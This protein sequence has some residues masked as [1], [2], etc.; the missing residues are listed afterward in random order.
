MPTIDLSDLLADPSWVSA[1]TSQDLPTYLSKQRWYTSKGA[2]IRGAK[3]EALPWDRADEGLWLLSLEFEAAQP[4]TRLLT[5]RVAGDRVADD[6]AHLLSRVPGGAIVEA[7][8]DASFR[9]RLYRFIRSGATSENA[10]GTLR[11]D[12]GTALAEQ[13][14]SDSQLPPQNS[15]N[16]V[17]VYEPDGFLKLFRKTEPGLHPDAE[18]IRYLSEECGFGSVPVY[19]GALSFEPATGGEPLSL[20]LL[21]G[22]VDHQGEAWETTLHDVGEYARRYRRGAVPEVPVDEAL[23]TPLN[24]ADVDERLREAMGEDTLRRVRLLGERTA[25]LHMHLASATA[26]SLR[27]E[28]LDQGYWLRTRTGLYERLERESRFADD[29]SAESLATLKSWLER[30]ELPVLPRGLIRVHGDYHLGQVLDTGD[31]LIVIDFEGEPLHS[32]AYRRARHAAFKDVA[33]ML[34]S[35]HYAPYAY[36]LN[37]ADGADWALAAAQPWY[38]VASRLFLSTYLERA[39]AARFIPTDQEERANMLAFFLA[40][41]ALYELAYERASRPGWTG[42]PVRGLQQVAAMLTSR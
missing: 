35:L 7:L 39:G 32:L 25:E 1:F 20:G 8:G 9:E 27:P 33:G 11:G 13:P 23:G 17:V 4:E 21:L 2:V 22:K 42:I 5:V 38:A 15:S 41:K 30:V 31:D 40:D 26:D 16:T 14:L 10:R 37:E 29:T 18:L 34:R 19:G 28:V 12:V 6:D 3:L 36:A 24:V